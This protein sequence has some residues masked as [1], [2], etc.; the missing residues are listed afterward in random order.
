VT[1]LAS[2]SAEY[3][4]V[5][6]NA[7]STESRIPA[8]PRGEIALRAERAT[9]SFRTASPAGARFRSPMARRCLRFAARLHE[10]GDAVRK[11]RHRRPSAT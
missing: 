2:N 9:I 1:S 11:G 3:A 4:A 10:C 7:V 5:W 6:S 8:K